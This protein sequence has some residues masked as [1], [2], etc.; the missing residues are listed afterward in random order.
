MIRQI[1]NILRTKLAPGKEPCPPKNKDIILDT[2]D[3]YF[4]PEKI[5][6]FLID[7]GHLKGGGNFLNFTE[8]FYCEEEFTVIF[9][10]FT[11][12]KKGDFM[13]MSFYKSHI[14]LP[15]NYLTTTKMNKL[16]SK[17]IKKYTHPVLE[18]YV[19]KDRNMLEVMAYVKSTHCKT[20]TNDNK[21]K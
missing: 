5:S 14:S 17:D 4:N 20:R 1:E 15:F 9:I 16:I 21:K 11:T 10:W 19:E 7:N 3:M 8:R 2:T 13:K 6:K 18:E 12:E